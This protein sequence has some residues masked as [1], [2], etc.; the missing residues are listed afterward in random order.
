MSSFIMSML[1]NDQSSPSIQSNLTTLA[2]HSKEIQYSAHYQV[3]EIA[4]E[5][6]Q[7]Q[8][9]TIL[10]GIYLWYNNG[11]LQKKR[12]P[13]YGTIMKRQLICSSKTQLQRPLKVFAQFY[14]KKASIKYFN[15]LT[16][17]TITQMLTYYDRF[18]HFYQSICSSKIQLQ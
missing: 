18:K 9:L 14:S 11:K 12:N 15:G 1:E 6:Q 7:N 16:K 2:T 5:F 17:E 3:K 10:L 4:I 8:P 13:F